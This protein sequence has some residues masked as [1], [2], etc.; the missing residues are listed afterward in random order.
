MK[1]DLESGDL[2]AAL[3]LTAFVVAVCIVGAV[4]VVTAAALWRVFA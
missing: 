2:T 3:A 4:L 1:D